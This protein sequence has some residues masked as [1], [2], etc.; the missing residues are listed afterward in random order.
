[1]A[2][3]LISHKN[4]FSTRWVKYSLR[5]L[6]ILIFLF[7]AGYFFM[8]YYVSN[9]KRE[10]LI[11]ITKQLNESLAGEL[12]V[13]SMEPALLESFP[14]VSLQLNN[15]TIK[16]SL[17]KQHK[18]TV[19]SAKNFSI[20]VNTLAML[21][22]TIEIRKISI[23]DAS[24]NIFTDSL[25]YSN[26]SVFKKKDKRKSGDGG[27]FP[28]LKEFNLRNV[29][30]S[31]DNTQKKKRFNFKITK[32]DGRIDYN[33]NGWEADIKLNAFAKSMAFS[34]KKGSFIKDQPVEGKLDARYDAEL[35][36]VI[37][38]P[39]ALE[40][41]G[42][43]FIISA[44]FDVGAK[45]NFAIRIQNKSIR[46]RKASALLSPNISS[47]LNMFDLQ[48]P[49]SIA[50]DIKGDMNI[51]GD[52]LIY[53]TTKV[54]NNFLETPGGNVADCNFEGIFT[55]NYKK[56]LG[57]NDAN[58][59]ILFNNFT[60]NYAEIPMKMNHAAIMN[61]EKPIA[62]GNFKSVFDIEKINN[63]IDKDLIDFSKGTA[64]V[65][66]EYRADIE[67]YKL[68]KP[69]VEGKIE[70]KGAAVNYVARNLKF[71]DISVLLDFKDENLHIS[72]IHLRSGKRIPSK[73][74]G[75]DRVE[76]E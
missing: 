19:L 6:A 28:E 17:Y 34:T 57:F 75:E 42:E 41:G 71:N 21:R 49:I 32:L 7:I 16:D 23:R 4:F 8:A 73:S 37:L 76:N 26:T 61:L 74:G 46:W 40:I 65:D 51:V 54:K 22:G 53:V 14:S 48:K 3:K 29:S 31:I 20:S 67:N 18:K 25:G 44:N 12:T 39:G 13:G 68:T 63:I 11:S 72:N 35:E 64:N 56:E 45:S 30:L 27:D 55:N 43:K 69:F 59:A 47:R 24:V 5:A 15:V 62:V 1:M 2:D 70:I 9:H 66:L 50:C 10:L 52:P 38:S 58:S 36:Q 33:S 60:G